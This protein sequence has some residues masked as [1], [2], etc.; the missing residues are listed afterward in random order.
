MTFSQS[1]AAEM[2]CCHGE[3]GSRRRSGIVASLCQALMVLALFAGFGVSSLLVASL[4]Q[5]FD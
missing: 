5:V 4:M 2:A 3:G 1:S